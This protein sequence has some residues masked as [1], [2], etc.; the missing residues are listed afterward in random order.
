MGVRIKNHA[1][2]KNSVFFDPMSS[3]IFLTDLRRKGVLLR[4]AKPGFYISIGYQKDGS[5]L[6]A[7]SFFP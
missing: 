5:D 3:S 2:D 4:P 1:V 7:Y 6:P